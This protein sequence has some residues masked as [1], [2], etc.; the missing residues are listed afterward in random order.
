MAKT[1]FRKRTLISSLLF[2]AALCAATGA[3]AQSLSASDCFA[4]GGFCDASNTCIGEQ[5]DANGFLQESPIGNCEVPGIIIIGA[6]DMSV[7]PPPGPHVEFVNTTRGSDLVV[8]AKDTTRGL[9][10]GTKQ[11]QVN[12]V[13]TTGMAKLTIKRI[14]GSAGSA[15]FDSNGTQTITVTNG[16]MITIFGGDTSDKPRNMS[17]TAMISNLI[18][19][20][21]FDF[22]VFRIEPTGIISGLVNGTSTSVLPARVKAN[23]GKPLVYATYTLP[24]R[25][26]RSYYQDVVTLKGGVVSLG[27]DGK[28]D[29]RGTPGVP[30]FD[31]VGHKHINEVVA[32]GGIVF[33]GQVIPQGIMHTDFSRRLTPN[34][35]PA[36]RLSFNWRQFRTTREQ[37]FD[38]NGNVKK[39]NL[40][41][42]NVDDDM[43]DY[44]EDLIPSTGA[45]WMIDEPAV[46]AQAPKGRG[47][48]VDGDV[49]RGT[50]V[51]ETWV[52]YGGVRVS[53]DV[54]WY[55]LY[56]HR[57]PVGT[58]AF[59]QDNTFGTLDNKMGLTALTLAPGCNVTR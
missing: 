30:D 42:N 12:V 4:A 51:F 19:P 47:D 9:P 26:M 33:R 28:R 11:L 21:E 29:E 49:V 48:T 45:V 22:T 14:L 15:A 59:V 41:E 40:C 37:I 39:T 25:T 58:P 24:A 10:G 5:P 46:I 3:N 38:Q 6:G 56:S 55:W 23:S 7:P 57:D 1:I 32:Y 53:P 54:N 31:R 16:Q 2:V 17:I 27:P 50:E 34:L 43:D 35:P 36:S 13:P 44:D 52:E 8:A 20:G 18:V